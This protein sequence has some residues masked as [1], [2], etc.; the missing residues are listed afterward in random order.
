MISKPILFHTV[1]K[2]QFSPQDRAA[3]SWTIIVGFIFIITACYFTS[4]ASLR[5]VF[6]ATAF[7]VAVFLYL[8]HPIHYIGFT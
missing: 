2:E 8:R 1:L 3:Q 6:P 4:T 7:I 5:L